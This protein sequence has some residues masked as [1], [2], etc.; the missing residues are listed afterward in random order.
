MGI[1]DFLKRDKNNNNSVSLIQGR[2]ENTDELPFGW[3]TQNKTFV[4]KVQTDY[5]YFLKLWIDNRNGS[6]AEYYQALKSFVVFLKDTEKMC[7]KQGKCFETWFYDIVASPEYI[8]KREKELEEFIS[9]R[10]E[11]EWMYEKKKELKPAIIE[12]IKKNN[13]II[14]SE[15]KTMFDEKLHNEVSNILYDMSKNGEVERVKTGRS[16]KLYYRGME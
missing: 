9:N 14:Q 16:Y 1:F 6:P 8:E 11:Y 10:E 7:K 5:D 12:V 3:V 2:N 15:L 4:D 13:G